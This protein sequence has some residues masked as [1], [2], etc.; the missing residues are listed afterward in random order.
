MTS[1]QRISDLYAAAAGLSGP[2]AMIELV[3][4]DDGPGARFDSAV[5]TLS[6]E[7]QDSSIAALD[8]LLMAA[9]QLRW[10]AATEP[11][12]PAFSPSRTSVVGDIET[13]A[14]RCTH[15]VSK[16]T[17]ALLDSLSH[18]AAGMHLAEPPLG[19][20]LLAAL[21]EIGYTG[22]AVVLEKPRAADE[23]RRW[24]QD[25]GVEVPV[26]S[27]REWL[28]GEVHEQA[29]LVGTPPVFGHAAVAAPRA[30][31]MAYLFPSWVRGRQ[32]PTTSFS[33]AARSRP[34]RVSAP[35]APAPEAASPSLE[36]QGEDLLVPQPVWRASQ[37]AAAAT[38]DDDVLARRVLLCG[39]LSIMLDAEGGAIRCLSPEQPPGERVEWRDVAS[40][41]PGAFLVLREGQTESDV[42]YARAIGRLG[43]LASGVS[44]S[45]DR[46]KSAL[47]LRLSQHGRAEVTRQLRLAGVSAASQAPAWLAQTVVRPQ[48]DMDFELVLRWLDLGQQPYQQNASLLRSARTAAT[49]EIRNALER[50]LAASDMGA[51]DRTGIAKLNLDIDGFAGILATRVL[52]ISPYLESVPRWDARVP[53]KDASAR[54]L[55]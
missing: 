14:D 49:A 31:T 45:Q 28:A 34:I 30:F 17:R 39:E 37:P 12:P 38:T 18:S 29:Y 6:L 35:A 23:T 16:S 27:R 54:W 8:E 24:L 15:L 10:R 36:A 48:S 20:R 40:V 55:E 4:V 46:W 1:L 7:V 47:R 41:A 11:A 21:R 52:A 2:A 22:C 32:L 9:R 25:L 51:L 44:A 42:L 13:L 3:P 5:Q 53:R 33:Q 26:L 43:K 19:T 50:A